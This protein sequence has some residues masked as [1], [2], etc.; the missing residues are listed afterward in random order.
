MADPIRGASERL[1]ELSQGN[2]KNEVVEFPAE[3]DPSGRRV[4]SV[5]ELHG[6]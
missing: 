6:I 1:I 4:S 3:D 2:L 5:H